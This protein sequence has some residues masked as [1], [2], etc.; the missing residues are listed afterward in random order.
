MR[1]Y[2]IAI[3]PA[4]TTQAAAQLHG[5]YPAAV[6][7]LDAWLSRCVGVEGT[8]LLQ[9]AIAGH[10]QQVKEARVKKA[11]A[12][13][14]KGLEKRLAGPVVGLLDTFPAG[15]WPKL[16]TLSREAVSICTKE[17]LMVCCRAAV[18][19]MRMRQCLPYSRDVHYCC[20]QLR[21]SDFAS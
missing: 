16:H 10:M 20:C 2:H 21:F 15:L 13:V 4:P 8:A 9:Q 3:L 14:H 12:L 11:L 5:L 17:L 19:V 7:H 18:H 6:S 1:K